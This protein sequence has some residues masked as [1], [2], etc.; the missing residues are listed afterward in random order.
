M[1]KVALTGNI[2]SGK[3]TVEEILKALGYSFLNTDETSHNLLENNTGVI[4]AVFKDFDITNEQGAIS[5][6]KIGKIVFSD[7]KMLKALEEIIHPLV[8]E[9]IQEFFNEKED[10]NLVFVAIPQLFESNMQDMFD[11]IVLVYC[12]DKIRFNR[13][14][15]RNNYTKDYAEKRINA[16]IPQSEKVKLSDFVIDN[17][18]TLENLQS[19]VKALPAQL[20]S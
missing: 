17:S 16:Q 2:A 14:I 20:I 3:S 6:E 18:S 5:R 12:D 1:I 10:E 7:K 13:L 11:K 19:L 4:K 9:K 8:R 15:K